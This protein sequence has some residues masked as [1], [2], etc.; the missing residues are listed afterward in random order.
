M[1]GDARNQNPEELG[2]KVQVHAT[3]YEH[4]KLDAMNTNIKTMHRVSE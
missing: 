3:L 4:M 1:V 2:N